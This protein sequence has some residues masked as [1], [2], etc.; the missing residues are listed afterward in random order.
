MTADLRVD[1]I[2]DN[3]NCVVRLM[4]EKEFVDP[5]RKKLNATVGSKEQYA[6]LYGEDLVC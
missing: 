2:F 4:I 3:S 6:P 5:A 1:E